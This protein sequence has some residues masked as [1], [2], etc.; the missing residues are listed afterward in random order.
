MVT[1]KEAKDMWCPMDRHVKPI[2]ECATNT[3]SGCRGASCMMW[4]WEAM[5]R[6]EQRLRDGRNSAP[7]IDMQEVADLLPRQGY[8]GLAGKEEG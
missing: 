8:C 3:N 1:E 6:W 7:G 5:K 2:S 4:R